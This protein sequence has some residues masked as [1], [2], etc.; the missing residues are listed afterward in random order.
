MPRIRASQRVMPAPAHAVT[1]QTLPASVC[2]TLVDATA[3]IE[4]PFQA[5]QSSAMPE[6]MSRSIVVNDDKPVLT[7]APLIKGATRGQ[8]SRTRPGSMQTSC[9]LSR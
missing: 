3:S 5:T 4:E 7:I 9:V 6:R 1:T 8:I 2:W